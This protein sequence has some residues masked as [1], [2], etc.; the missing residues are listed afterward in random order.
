MREGGARDMEGAAQMDVQHG[1]E[2]FL[3]E[4]LHRSVADIAG[5][6][7][8]PVDPAIMVERRLY[9]GAA[10][11]RRGDAVGRD[12]RLAA[13]R[14]DRGHHFGRRAG[15]DPLAAHRAARIIDHDPGAACAEQF[16]IGAAKPTPGTGDDDDAIVVAQ[17]GHERAFRWIMQMMAQG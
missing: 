1:V 12:D 10:A 17:F 5:I 4:I 7:D 2:I 9:D 15:I 6:V 3:A 16:R 13:L 14:L 8:Q 11:L